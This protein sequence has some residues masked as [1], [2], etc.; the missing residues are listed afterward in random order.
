MAE[1]YPILPLDELACRHSGLTP[2]IA[3]SNL[4]AASVCLSRHYQA[5]TDFEIQDNGASTI[6]TLEWTSPSP[7]TQMA[8]A[9]TT[10]TTEAG[11]YA[12]AIAAIE[13][14]RGL[15]TIRRAETFTGADY[16]TLARLGVIS[17]SYGIAIG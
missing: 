4:E 17:K 6:V 13:Q 9:N 5:P 7:R 14:S 15:F 8:W 3:A 1:T 12:C 16:T 10:D 2:A 11:A